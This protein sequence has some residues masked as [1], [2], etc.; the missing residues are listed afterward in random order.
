LK[1]KHFL[2][3]TQVSDEDVAEI[4]DVAAALKARLRQGVPERSLAGKT[5]ALIFEKPSL[6][7]RVSFEVGMHQLG[8]HAL[9]LDRNEIGLGERESV[10]DVARVLSGMV[11]GVMI[12]T[13]SQARVEEF[14]A[15]ASVPVINGL[16]DEYHPCQALAD[17]LTLRE[18]WGGFAG[19]RLAY[20]GDGNNVARSL[21][22]ACGRVGMAFTCAAPKKHQLSP[23]FLRL[24]A[25]KVPAAKVELTDDPR[26]GVRGADAVYTDTWVSMGQEAQTAAKL[27]DFDGFQVNAALMSHAKPDAVFLHC[28]PAHRGQEVTDEVLDGPAAI[29]TAQAENRL[30]LQKALLRLLMGGPFG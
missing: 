17:L 23:E 3:V 22:A 1:A 27:R 19:R 16:T 15:H 5:L 28:L 21:A 18:R 8:G 13:F 2:S 6:R 10:K 7:T 26:A 14:A 9:S 25:E 12:R 11:S 20:V 30:H 29:V 24:L 4:L